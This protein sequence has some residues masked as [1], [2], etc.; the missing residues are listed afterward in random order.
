MSGNP[1]VILAPAALLCFLLYRNLPGALLFVR[2]AL[3][4]V[5]VL[6]GPAEVVPTGHGSAIAQMLQD[7]AELGFEPLGVKWE[8]KPLGMKQ[9]EFVFGS[10]AEHSYAGVMPVT[11]EAWLYFFTPFEGGATVITADFKWPAADE[12][13]YLAGGLPA[14]TP[15]E[16]LNAHRRR[17]QRLIAGGHKPI[18]PLTLA[19]REASCVAFYA[20][21][22]GKRETRRRE[23]VRLVFT[24]AA[25][26]Y[27]GFLAQAV[28]EKLSAAA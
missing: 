18:E 11:N 25:L 24:G 21:G 5:R 12:R 26:V 20:S 27:L 10:A 4:R 1:L 19:A 16:V 15:T 2:P 13:D 28:I 17:V 8:Q 7:V 23:L 14:A 9:K 22:P 3:T 6:G